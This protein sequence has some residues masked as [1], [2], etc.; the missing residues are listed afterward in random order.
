MSLSFGISFFVLEIFILLYYANVESD[1]VIDGSTKTAQH[2]IENNSRNVKVV[3]FK[4]GTSYVHHKRRH[5]FPHLHKT[6]TLISP[7]RKTYAKKK[8]HFTL[9]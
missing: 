7:K 2:S 1:N 4:L 9:L 6:K 5:H 8:R 3:F